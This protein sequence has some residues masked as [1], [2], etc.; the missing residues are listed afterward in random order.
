M[1]RGSGG[2]RCPPSIHLPRSA[3]P[4][5]H[6]QRPGDGDDPV[7]RSAVRRSRGDRGTTA[8]PPIPLARGS[9]LGPGDEWRTIGVIPA[10][11]SSHASNQPVGPPPAITTLRIGH[12]TA[13]SVFSLFPFFG[14]CSVQTLA[15]DDGEALTCRST[16]SARSIRVRVDRAGFVGRLSFR[17]A[18][19]ADLSWLRS[20]P[21]ESWCGPQPAWLSARR[22]PSTRSTWLGRRPRRVPYGS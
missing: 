11:A 13:F 15:A 2:G 19:G 5:E 7:S 10:R 3:K 20:P 6:P 14:W 16:A 1:R 9:V 12:V 22:C 8:G 17:Q 18:R 4:R 21:A